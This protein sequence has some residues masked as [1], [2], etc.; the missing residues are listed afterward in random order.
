VQGYIQ[1]LHVASRGEL[2]E[3]DQPLLS[4]Y[5]PELLSSQREFV[6]ALRM[7]DRASAASSQPALETAERLIE[8]SK[9]RLLQWNVADKQIAELEKLRKPSDNL[10]LLSP[11][12]GII[13]DVQA[14]QGRNVMVGDRLVELVDL[15]VVWVWA[16]FYQDDL[17]ILTKGLPLKITTSTYPNETFSGAVAVVDPFLDEVKRTA[18]VRLDVENAGMKLR[19]NMYVNAEAELDRGEGLAIP[20]DAIMPTGKRNIAFVDKGGGKLEPRFVELGAKFGDMYGVQNGLQAGERVVA[21]AN[22]LIDAEA[23]VQGALRSW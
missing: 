14:D 4:M 20:V 18:R 6:E 1:K 11:F 16:E 2:V 7:R 13:Q 3:K 8:S 21:S 12:R 23:K 22:F 15:S 19:P 17:P 9:Q 10:T 5:G